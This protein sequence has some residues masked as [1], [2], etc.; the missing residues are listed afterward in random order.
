VILATVVSP[1]SQ[2]NSATISRSEQ[3]D[4]NTGNNT[5]TATETPQ[6]ADLVLSKSVDNPNPNVGD[7]IN[8]TI[9]L[10]DNGPNSAT[11]VQVT[12]VLPSSLTFVFETPSQG[13]YNPVNGIW[14]VGSVDSAAARTLRIRALVTSA[15]ST[16]NMASITHSDQ[17]DPTPPIRSRP[18]SR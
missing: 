7:T 8:Y 2:T 11:N 17:F 9:T 15:T 14:T 18:T 12:D 4:P 1:N 6:Q 16:V 3:F 5:A 10:T 13:T